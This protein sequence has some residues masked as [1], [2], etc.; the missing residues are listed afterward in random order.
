M[1][2]DFVAG[3]GAAL[4]ALLLGALPPPTIRALPMAIGRWRP[5][6][7]A[8]TAALAAFLALTLRLAPIYGATGA[9]W[10]RTAFF[11]TY[12]AVALP[13]ALAALREGERE[14]PAE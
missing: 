14:K 3:A 1:G 4:P 8:A 12:F 9:A 6:T 7:A 11:W 10:A 13:F 5:T 2:E